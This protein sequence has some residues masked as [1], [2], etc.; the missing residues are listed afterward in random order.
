VVG[1]ASDKLAPSFGARPALIRTAGKGPLSGPSTGAPRSGTKTR[2]SASLLLLWG[3]ALVRKVWQ[4]HGKVFQR[5]CPS[6]F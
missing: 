5:N 3:V 2:F 4:S 1:V 6:R